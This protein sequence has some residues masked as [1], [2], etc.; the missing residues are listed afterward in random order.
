M[1]KFSNALPD[2]IKGW[3]NRGD[4]TNA[5]VSALLERV[6]RKAWNAMK[7]E[8]M[9]TMGKENFTRLINEG[10]RGGKI[11]RRILNEMRRLLDINK[12]MDEVLVELK[13]QNCRMGEMGDGCSLSRSTLMAYLSRLGNPRFF[14]AKNITD[15]STAIYNFPARFLAMINDTNAVSNV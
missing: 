3:I 8:Q 9:M 6:P 10:E 5:N 1:D 4:F 7:L 2:R 13:Q 11:P 15:M 12:T 14:N